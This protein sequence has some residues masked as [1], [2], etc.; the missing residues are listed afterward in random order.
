MHKLR[1]SQIGKVIGHVEGEVCVQLE[2]V[3]A[4]LVMPAEILVSN[5][6]APKYK[7]L[8]TF[9]RSS[10][11]AKQSM[12]RVLGVSDPRVDNVELLTPKMKTLSGSQVDVFTHCC[13]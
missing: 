10:N 3:Q 1:Y 11:E 7:P 12:L 8:R 6:N 2:N 5:A 13:R 9:L 4:P